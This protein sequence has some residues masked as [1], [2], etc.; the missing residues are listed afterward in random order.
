MRLSRD[1]ALCKVV[2]IA[3]IVI[4]ELEREWASLELAQEQKRLHWQH[5]ATVGTPPVPSAATAG[6]ISWVSPSGL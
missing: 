3:D 5:D 6:P 1:H 4:L 2:G